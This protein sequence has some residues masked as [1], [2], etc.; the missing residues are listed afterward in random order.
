MT[1][2]PRLT[3]KKL[4]AALRRAGFEVIRVRGSHH[5]DHATVK[6]SVVEFV[7]EQ[8]HTNGIESFWVLLKRGYYGTFHKMSEKHL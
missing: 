1:K 3:A 8:A 7:R 6:H 4:I 5:V 2:L